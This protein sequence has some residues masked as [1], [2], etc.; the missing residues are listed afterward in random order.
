M[1]LFRRV[2]LGQESNRAAFPGIPLILVGGVGG[3]H[4]DG[5]RPLE[6]L[7]SDDSA[8]VTGQVLTVC[9]GMVT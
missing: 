3:T 6:L 5:R 4:D 1:K 7:A 8:Y 9:G 2:G